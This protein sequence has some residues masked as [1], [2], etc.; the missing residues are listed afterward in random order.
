MVEQVKAPRATRKTA[1]VPEPDLH[2]ASLYINRELSVLEYY[3]RVLCQALDPRHPLLERVNFL[4]MAGDQVDEFFMI[5]V[6][7]LHEQIEEGLTAVS[8]DGMTAAQ[9]LAAVRRRVTHM[10]AEQSRILSESLLPELVENG[11]RVVKLSDLST[12]QRAGLRAYFEREVFPVLTPLAVDPGHPFPHISNLS[13]NLAVELADDGRELPYGAKMGTRFARVKIPDV[14]PRLLHVESVLGQHV[15]GKKAKYTFVWLDQLVA[16]NLSSLFPGIAVR[17]SYLFRVIRDADIEIHEEEGSDLRISVERGLRQRRF[18]ETVA[19][20]V[21]KDMPDHIRSVLAEGLRVEGDEIHSVEQPLGLVS[22]KQLH[23]ID[24]PELKYP[25]LVPRVASALVA[26]ESIVSVLDR[27]D[28]LVQHPYESF[29]PVVEMLTSSARSDTVLAIKQT[30]YRVGSDSPVVRA[31]LDAANHGKQVAV[32]VELKARFDEQSNIE[33]AGELERAG[34]HVVYGF[35]GLKTHAKVMLVIRKERDGIRRYVHAGTGNY[36]VATARG[37]IDLGLFTADPEFGADATDLFNYLTGYSQQVT[38][39]RFLVAPV[40]LRQGLLE[41]IKRE[42]TLHQKNGGGQLIFKM[43]SLVDVEFI[44]ALYQAS[45]AGV[46]IQL[47]VRGIC[48]LRPGLPGV[49]EHIRVVSLVGRFLEHSR[50]YYFHNGGNPEIYCG[51]ADLMPRNL[52]HRVEVLFPILR[53]ELCE[54]IQR[55]ILETQ[56]KDTANA[57]VLGADGNYERIKGEGTPFDSQQWS[58]EHG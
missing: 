5:R 28:V 16:Y 14:I 29:A 53:P 42:V 19:L 43:N 57:W 49:S 35:V 50:I 17:G 56:L 58:I 21:E 25:P 39:R 18:G 47:I 48:C 31:L 12:T 38:Y 41:R 30:L 40:N 51:S 36:N 4:A 8:A 7:D 10:F 44:R 26:G 34:V 46:E 23:S 2:A 20:M 6:S 22:L 3:H 13:V 9:Q 32:L 24:R 45:Q 27:R 54:R 15:N 37:Y 11:I 52:D 55:D 33:W 1:D